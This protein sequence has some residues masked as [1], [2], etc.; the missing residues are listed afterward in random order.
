MTDPYEDFCRHDWEEA[1]REK[2]YPVCDI[3]GERITDEYYYELGGY[4]F[5]LGCA[6][7]HRTE[8]YVN[9]EW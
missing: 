1:E 5:H 6:E 7:R 8:D 3:C 2:R 9:K 4:R